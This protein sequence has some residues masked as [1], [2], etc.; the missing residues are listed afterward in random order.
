MLFVCLFK[1]SKTVKLHEVGLVLLGAGAHHDESF[2]ARDGSYSIIVSKFKG[3]NLASEA[4]LL[5]VLALF[6][7]QQTFRIFLHL[8]PRKPNDA[9]SVLATEANPISITQCGYGVVGTP[10]IR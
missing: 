6:S 5:L 9:S 10:R 4:I 1:Q 2:G 3:I 7:S 8:S